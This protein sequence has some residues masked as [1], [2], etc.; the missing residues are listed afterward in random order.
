MTRPRFRQVRRALATWSKAA[1]DPSWS[2]AQQ[3]ARDVAAKVTLPGSRRAVQRRFRSEIELQLWTGFDAGRL[4]DAARDSIEGGAG[5]R[6]PMGA[7]LDADRYTFLV[8]ARILAIENLDAATDADF[9]AVRVAYRATKAQYAR[10][11]PGLAADP[12]IGHLFAPTT[13]EDEV[14]SACVDLVT[15]LGALMLERAKARR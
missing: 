15:L 7:Q 5:P 10:E 6:G 9:E 11:R 8:R 4:R 13:V 12:E 3:A 1:R 14:N 2:G